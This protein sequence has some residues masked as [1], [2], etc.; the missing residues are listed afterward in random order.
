RGGRVTP[1]PRHRADARA[2]VR[3][4]VRAEVRADVRRSRLDR[5]VSALL[6]VVLVGGLVAF[7]G[8]A[9]GPRV[10][11]YRTATML[12]GSMAGTID[13][14]DVVVSVPKPTEDVEVGDILTFHAPVADRHLETH[15]VI[16]VRHTADGSAVIR[17]Q[18]DANAEPDPWRATVR[19]DTVWQV[20]H[21]VPGIGD[22]VRA[23][24][25][26]VV[27]HGLFWLALGALVVLGSSLI[28]SR[29]ESGSALVLAE[30][31]AG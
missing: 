6:T 9:L 14:G 12:T 8:L 7:A 19:D 21:V 4:D 11:G 1:A 24:R 2:D 16:A 26:P 3:A 25:A 18:G 5:V 13:P 27:R 31:Q 15:R 29:D 20:V 10:L 17:T 30:R 23:L 28:W 22:A